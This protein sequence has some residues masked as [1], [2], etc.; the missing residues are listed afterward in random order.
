MTVLVT[1]A[2]K[3][4]ST[5]EIAQAV[6]H[7]LRDAGV[8]AECLEVDEAKSLEPYDAVVLGSAVY[9]KRWRG[10]AR[11]FLH[12]HADELSKRP[13]WI[14]SSG[15]VGS[16]DEDPDPEWIEPTKVVADAERLGVRGHVVFG[17][18]LPGHGGLTSR[19]MR[20]NIPEEFHD[21][22]DWDEIDAWAKS[23]AAQLQATGKKRQSGPD[24]GGRALA[25]PPG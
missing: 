2:S 18:R 9:M 1:Y 25:Q 16:P 12:H 14:F 3:H 17:G 5:A 11:R 15:P 13:F 24:R 20:H 22:R 6:A 19:A 4:G 21:R 8:D 7:G 23:V 10:E